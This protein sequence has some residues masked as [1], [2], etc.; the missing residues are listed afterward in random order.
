MIGM[1]KKKPVLK[2]ESA[3]DF[4]ENS[5]LPAKN[6]I[7]EWYKRIP[8]FLDGAI[9]DFDKGFGN[10][11]VK[12]CVPFLE[13]FTTGYIISLPYDLYVK[14]NDGSPFLT[15]TPSLEDKYAPSWRDRVADEK[16][17]PA[18]CYPMEY[19]WN[20]CVAYN[21][22]KE[23][24]FLFTHPLNRH[25]LPFITLS[26]II[27]GGL[28]MTPHG[29]A[30]FYIKSG[31]EGVIPRGT[32]IAQLIPFRRENWNSKKTEGLAKEG[33]KNGIASTTVFSGWY[34]KIFWKRK[35]YE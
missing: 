31:F 2:Y 11:T 8:T 14:D 1:F 25:D 13:S 29:S 3:I 35:K 10:K 16:I 6:F 22:P 9:F 5:I 23:Y 24:S 27:D 26:A 20:Y 33:V 19:T 18:G 28:T 7:P 17:V 30:P 4:V 12:N 34:K 32:P 15:W 21:V